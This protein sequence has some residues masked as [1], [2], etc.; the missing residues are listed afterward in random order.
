MY[1]YIHDYK[2]L[3]MNNNT[4]RNDEHAIVYNHVSSGYTT[5]PGSK[6]TYKKI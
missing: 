2:I 1:I 3:Y 6:R 5:Y 4:N